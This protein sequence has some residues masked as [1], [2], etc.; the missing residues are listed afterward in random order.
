MSTPS[1]DQPGDEGVYQSDMHD[2]QERRRKQ[3]A[4]QAVVG[5]AGLA[6]LG[7]GAYFV[8]TQVTGQTTETRDAGAL[9]PITSAA[10]SAPASASASPEPTAEADAVTPTKGAVKQSTSP[11]PSPSPSRSMS[12]EQEI[13]EARE[14]AAKDGYNVKRPV[15]PAPNAATGPVTEHNENR[16]N[17]TFRV[18]TARHDLSGQR[19]LLWVANGGESVGSADCTQTFKFSN[20][21]KPQVKKNMLVCWRTSASRS[22]VTVMVDYN[23]NPSKTDSVKAID[24]EWAKLG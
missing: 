20:N 22:V 5:V 11:T 1:E 13:K 21:D 12:V 18:V 4:K 24:R 14:K 19:E 10:T 23:G 16:K 15:T 17:G 3:R 2:R 9:A 7:A 6:V 8:T